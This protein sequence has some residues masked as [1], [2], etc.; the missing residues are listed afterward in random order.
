[1]KEPNSYQ[2]GASKNDTNQSG[3]SSF[4]QG[5]VLAERYKVDA[6]LGIGGMGVVYKVEQI[7][8]HKIFAM[9]TLE[10]E[11]ATGMFWRR[12]QQEGEAVSRLD[13]PNVVKI[14]DFGLID[15]K[16]PFYVMDFIDGISLSG[17]LKQLGS[18]DVD[19]ALKIFIRV[20][21]ALQHA[22][23]TE[24]IHRDIKPSNIMLQSR[25][26]AS[27][28]CVKLVDFG[29]AKLKTE[30]NELQNL[31][32]TGDVFGSPLYMSPEQCLGIGVD[33]RTDIYSFGCALFEALTG[34]PPHMGENSLSTMIKHR[35][36]SA[37]SLSE[38]SLGKKFSPALEAVVQKLLQ[39]K[40]DDRYQN[41]GDVTEDLIALSN[42]KKPTHVQANKSDNFQPGATAKAT[43]SKKSSFKMWWLVSLTAVAVVGLLGWYAFKPVAKPPVVAKP[44]AVASAS[45]ESAKK[46]AD[47]AP[48]SPELQAFYDDGQ[49]RERAE[50]ERCY[51]HD[52]DK[53]YS[54][55]CIN[56]AHQSVRVFQF[57]LAISLGK[58]EV[59]NKKYLA[60]GDVI[61]PEP[62]PLAF[63][64]SYEC[65]ER[66]S[67]L[68]NFRLDEIYDLDINH[69]ESATDEVLA[70][71]DKWK[72]LQILNIAGNDI[73][74]RGLA[75]L[76]ENSSLTDLRVAGTPVTGKAIAA[77]K[78]L[79]HL[80][81]FEAGLL[82]EA[83]NLLRA[84]R[85][86][87]CLKKLTI[88][89]SKLIDDDLE[90]LSTITSLKD[91]DISENNLITDKGLQYLNLPNLRGLSIR[92]CKITE[93]SFPFLKSLPRLSNIYIAEDWPP[94][95][96]ALFHEMMPRVQLRIDNTRNQ[97]FRMLK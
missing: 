55:P 96:Q 29:I 30:G 1:M 56:A 21:M 73:T 82:T 60:Q 33:H 87:K 23:E 27:E 93:A 58:I 25:N 47:K 71:I 7:F 41:F 5:Q 42:G 59:G 92:Q 66:P 53:K 72:N 22:H 79:N 95:R 90:N 44:V 64:P 86:S 78:C 89:G 74:N 61:I 49:L 6:V 18:L 31:T 4:A 39:K 67:L 12:F 26:F 76:A 38:G 57:P 28:S 40:P 91:I 80:E 70:H 16:M 17:L 54:T 43:A 65:C 45:T 51:N 20:S 75:Y 37:P 52:P 83:P 15:G 97:I 10:I 62:G 3:H 34:S 2:T 8:L 36:E 46:K 81:R 50:E 13:H 85:G 69:K 84:L 63:T 48:V 94:Q 24:I 11:D 88:Q 35:E 32:R 68:D 77:L 19:D 9:K 14:Y